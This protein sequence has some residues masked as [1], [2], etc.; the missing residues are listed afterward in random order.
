MYGVDYVHSF[1][2]AMRATS[3]RLLYVILVAGAYVKLDRFDVT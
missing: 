1:F 2:A 3:F